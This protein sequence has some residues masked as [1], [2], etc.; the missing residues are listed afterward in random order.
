MSRGGVC[1]SRGGCACLGVVVCMSRGGCACLGV[2]VACA[3][4]GWVCMSRG[5]CACLG[6]CVR[7]CLEVGVHV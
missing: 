7:A 2:G 5:G 1:M 3:C 6:V 4:L